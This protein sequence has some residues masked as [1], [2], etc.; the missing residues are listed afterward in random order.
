[1]LSC[2]AVT[3]AR[4]AAGETAFPQD[5][6]ELISQAQRATNAA[7]EDGV[8]LIE[9]EFP[10]AGLAAVPGDAE[11][12]N[13]MS[14]SMDFLRSYV[15]IFNRDAETTRIYFPDKS[16]LKLATKGDAGKDVE[17]R[18]GD[19]KFQLDY[20]QNPTGLLD[21]GLDV[22]KVDV[23]K[24]VRDAD[25]VFVIGYPHFQVQEML[26]VWDLYKAAAQDSGR[27]IIVFNG[28]LDR[29]R[30]PWYYP[31]IF[32]PKVAKMG[33]EFIPGFEQVYYLKNFKGSAPGCLFRCYPGPW[34]VMVRVSP[35]P[36]DCKTVWTGDEMPTLKEVQMSILPKATGRGPMTL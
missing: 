3:A 10:S 26:A 20:L 19:V 23:S 27:P 25:R 13:E 24:R 32:Y 14:Y 34:Q 30:Q 16:E 18:F 17:P 31:P 6:S 5:F 7:L 22:R 11:G 9:V 4:A 2:V 36:S 28:E 33:K 1:M 12:A 21:I 8:K 15:S 29:I 35:D